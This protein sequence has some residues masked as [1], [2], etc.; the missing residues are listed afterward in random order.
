MHR[1]ILI[2][3]PGSIILSFGLILI[4][5]GYLPLQESH[6][7]VGI[8]G[9]GI[10]NIRWTPNIRFGDKGQLSLEII[11][12][13][14]GNAHPGNIGSGGVEMISDSDVLLVDSRLEIWSAFLEPGPEVLLTLGKG[15]RQTVTWKIEPSRIGT[16]E[17]ELWVYLH[18]PADGTGSFAKQPVSIQDF[19][20]SSIGLLGLSGPLARLSGIIACLVALLYFVIILGGFQKI[21]GNFTGSG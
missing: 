15:D 6:K 19:E 12:T 17:P 7:S 21:R 9:I 8:P 14:L 16:F 2:F 4:S 3:F 18:R 10:Q 5:W 13:D 20:L 1:P 11:R